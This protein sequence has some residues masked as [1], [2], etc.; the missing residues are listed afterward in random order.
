MHLRFFLDDTYTV[1]TVKFKAMVFGAHMLISSGV[2]SEI[3]KVPKV[4][5]ASEAASR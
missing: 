4:D 5:A 3:R 1:F 2:E